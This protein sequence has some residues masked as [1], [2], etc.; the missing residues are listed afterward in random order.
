[1]ESVR[2]AD[3]QLRNKINYYQCM[4]IVRF[5]VYFI[6]NK[7]YMNDPVCQLN[8]F[9]EMNQFFL[10]FPYKSANFKIQ[11]LG[12]QPYTATFRLPPFIRIPIFFFEWPTPTLTPT[13]YI[14]SY[15]RN[16]IFSFDILHAKPNHKNMHFNKMLMWLLPV[17]CWKES[18]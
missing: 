14:F 13:N 8:F 10:M 16:S 5:E 4:K 17:C 18:Q 1:M 2:A 7:I 3:H 15:P 6:L 11:S 9:S 12:F